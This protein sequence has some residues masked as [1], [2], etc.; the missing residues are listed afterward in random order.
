VEKRGKKKKRGNEK[1]KKKKKRRG[2]KKKKEKKK[3]RKEKK[4]KKKDGPTAPTSAPRPASASTDK[5]AGLQER[6]PR[7]ETP[8]RA[9]KPNP[10][11][12]SPRPGG[13]APFAQRNPLRKTRP[14]RPG[15]KVD[16]WSRPSCSFFFQTPTT[17]YRGCRK[18][19]PRA[20]LWARI[21]RERFAARDPRSQMLRFPPDRRHH[22]TRAQPEN[23]IVRV[24]VS[25]PRRGSRAAS[26][27]CTQLDVRCA[28]PV[29]ERAAVAAIALRD[30]RRCWPT[31]SLCGAWPIPVAGRFTHRGGV[32][33]PG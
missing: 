2:K 10:E 32:D 28:S 16:E 9:R 20:G 17:P 21:M 3:K 11:A 4:K 14:R 18:Y 19:R 30:P 31:R 15:F 24:A 33:H 8:P 25:V 27:R 7:W 13:A 5:T 29:F 26:V 22:R 6:G 1:K 23:N 12:G